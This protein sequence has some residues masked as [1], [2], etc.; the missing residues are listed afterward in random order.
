MR[1]AYSGFELVNPDIG[2]LYEMQPEIRIRICTDF[3]AGA[4]SEIFVPISNRR[5]TLSLHR[6]RR[7]LGGM[8]I[9]LLAFGCSVQLAR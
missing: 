7:R 4:V 3:E 2:T 5:I 9:G 1:L 8:E 6:H